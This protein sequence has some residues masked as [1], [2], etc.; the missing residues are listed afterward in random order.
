MELKNIMC[1]NSILIVP[2]NSKEKMIQAISSL[3]SFYAY[4]IIDDASLKESLFFSYDMNA[5]H[6]LVKKYNYKPEN[7]IQYIESM[8]YIQDKNYQNPTLNFI[9]DLKKELIQ[10]HLLKQDTYF[11][12]TLKNK[13]IIVYG[14]DTIS[15]E[16]LYILSQIEQ[17]YQI[18]SNDE[19]ESK[20]QSV[21]HFETLEDEVEAL[22]LEISKLLQ[23]NVDINQIKIANVNQDYLFTLKRYFDFY[24]IPCNFHETTTLYTILCV[25]EF[26]KSC[27]QYQDYEKALNEFH[28]LYSY[29]IE[30]YKTLVNIVNQVITLPFDDSLVLLKYL[31]KNGK[32]PSKSLKKA[33]EII[34]LDH[35]FASEDEYLF[36]LSVNQGIYPK[37]FKDEDFLS[38]QEKM[39]LHIDTSEDLN[40]L[41]K[42]NFHCLLKKKAHIQLSYKEKTPFSSFTKSFVLFEENIM[43]VNYQKDIFISYSSEADE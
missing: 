36:V 11:K 33:V 29:E 42:Q 35:Y 39:E 40:K 20:I 12:N 4:K 8:Y 1:D 22:C 5:I 38:D 16:M 26:Y 23:K 7:A 32:K 27:L 31:L 14:F 25:Q 2:K 15:K 21:Y 18:I 41:S 28:D 3:P 17:D 43:D 6:Y 37:N 24:H 30:L 9:R 34:S 19:Q 13:K 10:N